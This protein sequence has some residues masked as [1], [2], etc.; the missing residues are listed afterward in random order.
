MQWLKYS[1]LSLTLVLGTN[2]FA[3]N[4]FSSKECLDA[5]YQTKIQHKGKFFGLLEN[6]LSIEKDKCLITVTFKGILE[7]TWKVDVCREPIH[8]KVTSKGS[9]EVYK[10]DKKCEDK[11]KS[12]Y[13]Y[14][15]KELMENMQDHGLIFAQG[16]REDISQSHGQTYCSYLLLQRYLD[17]GVVFSSFESPKNI[18]KEQTTCDVPGTVKTATTVTI[19]P[20]VPTSSA[21]TALQEKTS[22]TGANSRGMR[23][24]TEE[25]SK[26]LNS[27]EKP[28]F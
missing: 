10:R 15:R 2:A 7:T 4:K 11:T 25:D 5:K 22:S 9:Q 24:L 16:Q 17:D 26:E 21:N 6:K 1:F 23:P 12:D 20:Q 8:M 14:F 19:K 18:Y 13:C 27:E 28:K 3:N